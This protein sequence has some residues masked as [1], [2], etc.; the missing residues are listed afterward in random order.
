M[1]APR[2]R[3]V[4]PSPSAGP[5]CA[6][7]G[8]PWFTQPD[9]FGQLTRL[10]TIDLRGLPPSVRRWFLIQEPEGWFT[11][12][13]P[14]LAQEFRLVAGD[15]AEVAR[16]TLLNFCRHWQVNASPYALRYYATHLRDA[17]DFS[18]LFLLAGGEGF[19]LAQRKKLPDD[20][21]TV[22]KTV[23]TAIAA[24][25]EVD[26]PLAM[27]EFML[28]HTRRLDRVAREASPLEVA[29]EGNWR[30]ALELAD[31]RRP[32]LAALWHLLVAWQL[33]VRGEWGTVKEIMQRLVD[34]ELPYL[35]GWHR[36]FAVTVLARLF[37][38]EEESVI[39]L[40]LKLF[41]RT[42]Q[43][44]L[45]E[46]LARRGDVRFAQRVAEHI[47]H[48]D[49][50][51]LD[52][53][54]LV[55]V[56]TVLRETNSTSAA[57]AALARARNLAAT[58]PRSSGLWFNRWI[59]IGQELGLLDN[60][61]ESREV[62]SEVLR[63]I[64]AAGRDKDELLRRVAEAQHLAGDAGEASA[65]FNAVLESVGDFASAPSAALER[66]AYSAARMDNLD[67]AS[68]AIAK[69]RDTD[70]RALALGHVARDQARLSNFAALKTVRQIPDLTEVARGQAQLALSEIVAMQAHAGRFADALEV[71][72]Q[73]G[74][75]WQRSILLGNI[76]FNA[77]ALGHPEE[78]L[79]AASEVPAARMKAEALAT[80]ATAQARAGDRQG[81][82]A[83]LRAALAATQQVEDDE[84]D[85]GNLVA[86]VD[87]SRAQAFM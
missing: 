43:S 2:R 34:R 6:T 3:T 52:V 69:I 9:R 87:E 24:A 77:A 25:A 58:M 45:A 11:F 18:G 46:V 27:A 15:R 33:M 82:A 67:L 17:R 5:F 48:E 22:L 72:R 75:S 53:A 40:Q 50:N 73:I 35:G 68:G 85:F 20:P 57:A 65:T 81:A 14:L 54:A 32:E 7:F 13:H 60:R 8:G 41:N 30:R 78:A 70:N 37:G 63:A 44:L 16:K 83:T 76:V 47:G 62:F 31:L 12:A 39:S 51:Y 10:T 86:L 66:I 59:A 29:R 26:D 42:G 64:P 71:A 56:A 21:D 61:V 79:E 80:T 38:V 19:T 55:R 23:Q 28:L 74:D 1:G 4:T 36:Q 49:S 84:R